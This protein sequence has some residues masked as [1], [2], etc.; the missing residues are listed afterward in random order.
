M[1]TRTLSAIPN[2]AL[3]SEPPNSVG[4]GEFCSNVPQGLPLPLPRCLAFKG[5]PSPLISGPK[6]LSAPPHHTRR[7]LSLFP[8]PY[9]GLSHWEEKEKLFPAGQ[10]GGSGL[11][12]PLGYPGTL[13]DTPAVSGHAPSPSPQLPRLPAPPSR[14][15]AQRLPGLWP[16][17]EGAARK[18]RQAG[19]RPWGR[20]GPEG[21][22]GDSVK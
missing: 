8:L 21:R 10:S 20:R 14:K 6:S 19:W 22:G 5:S 15:G 18:F 12:G 1:L 3:G 2:H 16:D 4:K 11:S 13:K 7:A 9:L 17:W